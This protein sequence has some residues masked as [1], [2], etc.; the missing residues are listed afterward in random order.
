MLHFASSHPSVAPVPVTLTTTANAVH[1]LEFS[2]DFAA[3]DGF[4]GVS[5]KYSMTVTNTGN[6][7]DTFDLE[8][9]SIWN[10]ETITSTGPLAGG[11]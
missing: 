11:G 5:V 4:P 1:G 7:T 9:S 10:T 3:L 6:T 8:V 2:A